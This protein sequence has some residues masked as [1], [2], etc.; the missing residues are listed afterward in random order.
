MIPKY[1]FDE[2]CGELMVRPT[3][4][5]FSC[6][7]YISEGKQN[8][9]HYHDN[10]SLVLIL[11]GRFDLVNC[12]YE[13]SSDVPLFT[14]TMPYMPHE[15]HAWEDTK[16]DRYV[17]YATPDLMERFAPQIVDFERL[18]DANLL[19]VKPD[20][21]A[22]ERLTLLMQQFSLTEDNDSAA[23]LLPVLL[24]ILFA[25]VDAGRGEI[26]KMPHPYI[27]GVLRELAEHMD[28]PPTIDEV[29]RS[30]GVGRSKLQRDFKAVTGMPWHQYLTA[31]RMKRA[32]EL[33]EDGGG[34]LQT[35]L[36]CGYSTESHFIMAYRKFFG[37]TPGEVILRGRVE[38]GE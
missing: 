24:R 16:Y 15:D 22:L 23:L 25:E 12:G 11:S 20:A 2:P 21:S 38:Q 19:W 4:G 18:R 3:K 9:Q 13:L 28:A 35:A 8:P 29:C 6:I 27:N 37:E 1:N 32:K 14:V 26:V 10:Y 17:L 30:V 34:I 36:A 31:I 5:Q 7:R 33:L